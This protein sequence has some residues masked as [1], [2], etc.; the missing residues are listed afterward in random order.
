MKSKNI[1]ITALLSL[2]ISL[3]GIAG[4]SLLYDALFNV[5]SMVDEQVSLP[6]TIGTAPE[7]FMEALKYPFLEETQELGEEEIEAYLVDSEF[8]TVYEGTELLKVPE[9]T[10]NGEYQNGKSLMEMLDSMMTFAGVTESA[11]EMV[12]RDSFSRVAEGED[13]YILKR[14]TERGGKACLLSIAIQNYLPVSLYCHS[15][16]SAS[17]QEMEC[18]VEGL[19]ELAHT[20]GE[21]LSSCLGNIDQMYEGYMEYHKQINS[22]YLSL[23][24]DGMK[25]KEITE[26]ITLR[27]C[28][29]LGTWQ[30]FSD[31]KEAVLVCIMEKSSLILFYDAVEQDF[32]GFRLELS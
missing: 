31:D 17:P 7:A 9:E 12:N 13:C 30:V 1:L 23:L 10:I 16:T 20:Q 19:K 11:Y 5:A 18:A 8:Y 25:D 29:T 21:K 3:A 14:E 15:Q 22:L 4:F 28:C 26:G 32:C 27:D 6:D 2:I 24:P